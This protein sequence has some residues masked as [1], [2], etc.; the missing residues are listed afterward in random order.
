MSKRIL[1]MTERFA[2]DIGG[3]ARSATRTAQRFCELGYDCEVFSWTKQLPPGE[4]VTE[5]QS[6]ADVSLT[7]HRLGLF[8]NFDFSTQHTLN[9]IEW[10]HS[11]NPYDAVWGHYL[12][13]TGFVAVMLG[14][15]LNVSTLVSARGNDIDRLM[16][17]PGDFARLQWTLENADQ[18]VSVSKELAT[19]IRVLCPQ[20]RPVVIRNTVDTD[21]FVPQAVNQTLRTQL[22]IYPQE[23]VLGFCG[24]LR[25]KKGLPFLLSALQK[26]R[27]SQDACLLV[28]GEI[29]PREKST[30]YDYLR[31]DD[32]SRKR[33]LVTGHLDSAEQVVQHLNLCDVILAPS[34]WD[35]LPNALLEAMACEKL[36]IASNAGGIPEVIDHNEN[37]LML[38]KWQLHRLGEA[39]LEVLSLDADRAREIQANARKK[40]LAMFHPDRERQELSELMRT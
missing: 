35:G 12:F 27:S 19:K 2:P 4:L 26:V 15:L 21:T 40:I 3:V 24:E 22:G 29:R 13:P 9:V 28:I 34:V 38:P 1:M 18:V 37:G 30:I 31:D 7:T 11:Q 23:T 14:K 36:V 5:N 10:L 16:F 32:L 17:P 20:V 33:I 8:A 25:H 6:V 39:T